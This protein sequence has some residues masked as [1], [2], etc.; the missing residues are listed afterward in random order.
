MS[1]KLQK[2]YI[3]FKIVLSGVTACSSVEVYVSEERP[4]SIFRIQKYVQQEAGDK[5]YFKS[6]DV[7]SFPLCHMNRGSRSTAATPAATL[8]AHPDYRITGVPWVRI[9]F[10]INIR[11]VRPLQFR[12]SALS[13][14]W[15]FGLLDLCSSVCPHYLLHKYPICRTSAVPC[16]RIIFCINIRSVRPL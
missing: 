7:C 6:L 9:I 14:A 4:P 5:F 3:V 10:C 16:V 15:I 1:R 13:S 12:V 11:S 8:H 2:N